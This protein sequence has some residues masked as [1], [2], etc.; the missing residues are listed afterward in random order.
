MYIVYQITNTVN[1]K[2]YIGYS[3]NTLQERWSK[4]LESASRVRRGKRKPYRFANAINKHGRDAFSKKVLFEEDT[5]AGAKETEVLLILDQE[6]EYNLTLGGD[7]LSGEAIEQL[8]E[9]NKGNK[10]AAGRV[11]RD[12]SLEALSLAQ[13]KSH[14]EN[15]RVFT[16]E[17]LENLSKSQ[18]GRK[19][20][21]ETKAKITAA[22]TGRPCSQRC[23][24]AVAEANKRRK[25]TKQ[26]KETIE[27]RAAKLRGR[28]L[29]ADTKDKISASLTGVKHTPERAKAN[30]EAR[31]GKNRG[32]YKIKSER[33]EAQLAADARRKGVK[34]GP[35]KKKD[36]ANG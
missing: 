33:S 26:S 30:A 8:R 25:G 16:D 2:R 21:E 28:P 17:W 15:P 27:K 31:I 1:G 14:A 13:K 7:G 11:W 22:N 9:R 3:A 20:T 35:Y 36:K 24:D 6:P 32:P 18:I 23:K 10:Y 19:H 4:H 34:V 29:S 12:E 5:L